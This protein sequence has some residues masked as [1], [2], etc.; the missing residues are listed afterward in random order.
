MDCS[1][2]NVSPNY[3]DNN[4]SN[5]CLLTE[6]VSPRIGK[7]NNVCI[8]DA[9]YSSY[10]AVSW[11]PTRADLGEQN[12]ILF[13]PRQVLPK[14]IQSRPGFH[15]L[16]FRPNSSLSYN[17]NWTTALLLTPFCSFSCIRTID[18]FVSISV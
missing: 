15:N 4:N 17:A 14:L 12:G 16:F 10:Y 13:G 9:V 6:H 5:I 18:F 1:P 11:D 7:T 3:D 8:K 2:C